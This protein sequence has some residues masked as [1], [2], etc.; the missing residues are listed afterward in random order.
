MLKQLYRDLATFPLFPSNPRADLY[1]LH[2]LYRYLVTFP[3]LPS[4]L[5]AVI[6]RLE[7]LYR[8]LTIMEMRGGD[9]VRLNSYLMQEGRK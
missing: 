3:L 8:D 2:Q 9:G 4:N 1:I 7:Q 5:K 6:N